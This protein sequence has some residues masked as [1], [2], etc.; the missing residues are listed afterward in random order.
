M[1]ASAVYK[2]QVRIN[3]SFRGGIPF[4]R[5]GGRYFNP[6]AVYV[7]VAGHWRL[8]Y[9]QFTWSYYWNTGLWSGCACVGCYNTRPVWCTF[10]PEGTQVTDGL[11]AHLTKPVAAEYC[12]CN[13][14]CACC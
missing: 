10:H 13:C 7:K 9:S 2:A 5:V 8:S 6:K 3:G 12:N 1:A 14:A 4:I 11:C